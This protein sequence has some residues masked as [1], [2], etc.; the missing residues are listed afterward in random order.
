MSSPGGSTF[1]RA[2]RKKRLRRL[3]GAVRDEETRELLPLGEVTRR[4]GLFEQAH[5]GIRSI[6]IDAIVGTVDR[7][8]D[9]D[10]DFLPR[11]P[12]L[13][14]RWKRVEQAFPA[15]DFPPISVY[16]VDGRYFLID[17]HHRVAIAKQRGMSHIDAE[18][19]R[20]RTRL[21]LPP[22]ADIGRIIH[23]EQE[24][25]FMQESGLEQSRPSAR[26]PFSHPNGYVELL[27]HVKVHG[28]HLMH[29]RGEVLSPPEIGADWFDRVYLPGLEQI[30]EE[31]L[32]EA[33]PQ[34]TEG[35]LYLSVYQ[36]RRAMT[37][38]TGGMTFRDAA[39]ATREA[40]RPKRS[41][42]NPRSGRSSGSGGSRRR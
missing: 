10:R 33:F 16:E 1:D 20:L 3:A 36:R 30:R 4:L 23:A 29:E 5:G 17:G 32:F 13:R 18:V 19:I 12:E 39:R 25:Q 40:A 41:P 2:R 31:G 38:E 15:G 34:A 37:P 7:S 14:D 35:D 24:R 6:P 27:E 21:P 42:L 11:R 22:D 28:Y 8:K 26:I 9:F